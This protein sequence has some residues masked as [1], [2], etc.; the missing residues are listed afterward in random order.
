MRSLPLGFHH[1]LE[2]ELANRD[3]WSDILAM[4]GARE[5]LRGVRYPNDATRRSLY[6][7]WMKVFA[8][9]VWDKS[10]DQLMLK[11]VA[12]TPSPTAPWKPLFFSIYRIRD[13]MDLPIPDMPTPVLNG[14]KMPKL[15]AR[16]LDD[17]EPLPSSP[18]FVDYLADLIRNSR[19][20]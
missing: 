20:S 14:A 6:A 1:A 18:G 2:R 15:F 17:V 9:N 3:D 13:V 7:S 12:A 8:S 11:C 10:F 4:E 19:S 16:K 5:V